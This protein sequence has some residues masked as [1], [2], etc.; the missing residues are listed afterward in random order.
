MDAAHGAASIFSD[1]I[2][3]K[4]SL[5]QREVARR[6]PGR[7]DCPSNRPRF[8]PASLVGTLPA[9]GFFLAAE[10]TQ[11]PLRAFP[12]KNLPGV[13]GWECVKYPF[14]PCPLLWRLLVP[15][16]Q[17]PLGSWP[18]RLGG[19]PV[20]AYPGGCGVP[21]AGGRPPMPA[22]LPVPP[23]RPN[24]SKSVPQSGTPQLFILHSSFSPTSSLRGT[25]HPARLSFCREM[26]SAIMAINSLLVGLPLVLDTV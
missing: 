3:P 5:V 12:P 13:R 9:G 22:S 20:R 26:R 24:K 1:W 19:L 16:H 25:A 4:A 17:V 10:R 14:G 18:Y 11:R 15:P 7:R 21:A 6:K 8:R 2:W 23:L